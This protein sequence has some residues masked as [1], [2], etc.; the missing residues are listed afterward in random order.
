MEISEQ[1]QR[2]KVHGVPVHRYMNSENGLSLAREEIELQGV[3]RLKRDPV[4][5]V[6]PKKLRTKN[7]RN[8]IIVVTVGSK[9][10]ARKMLKFGLQF[11]TRR[12]TMEA[13][14]KV[15]PESV[16]TRCCGIEHSN[17]LRYKG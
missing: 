10:D 1:W 11:S 8:A 3:F 17:H 13:Y 6:S 2:V 15:N 5:L 4:W 16:C 12:Y 14:K 7:Q 9:D